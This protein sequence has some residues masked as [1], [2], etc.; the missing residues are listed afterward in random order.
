MAGKNWIILA[1][2]LGWILTLFF[3]I[4]KRGTHPEPGSAQPENFEQEPPEN[5]TAAEPLTSYEKYPYHSVRNLLIR[6]QQAEGLETAAIGFCLIGEDPEPLVQW[7]ADRGL[8]PASTLKTITSAT[9]LE[10]L[11]PDFSFKT[12]LLAPGKPDASGTIEGD[13]VFVG[14]GDPTLSSQDLKRWAVNLRNAGVKKIT[15]RIIGDARFF[16]ESIAVDAW[17]WGD[18]S[19][20]YGAGASGLN[21]DHNRF[22][23]RFKPAEQPG[24]RADFLGTDPKL[25]GVTYVNR[26]LTGSPDSGDGGSVYG[27]PYNNTITFRG[28]VPMG[29]EFVIQGA[30]P[31]PALHA[32]QSLTRFLR[33]EGISVGRPPTTRRLLTSLEQKMPSPTVALESH[34]SESLFKIITHLH[35]VSDN[36]EAEC[37]FRY[38]G[39]RFRSRPAD[40]IR[41]HWGQKDISFLGLRMEDG[42]G[43]A[44]ANLIRPRDLAQ[45]VYHTRK[46]VHG[47]LFYASL[48]AYFSGQVRWKGGAMSRVRCYTGFVKGQSGQEYTFALMINNHDGGQEVIRHWRT[49]LINDLLKL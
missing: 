5:A 43:L 1:L 9:A 20:Y 25:E 18:V 33:L 21:L 39:Q 24:D 12:R 40:L 32:A 13:L 41:E 46:G 6:M 3:H 49:A 36:V 45:V 2:A 11:G 27:G 37:L 15:G 8:I 38:L 48:N 42:S 47:D 34:Q 30:V 44:R 31:D 7:N 17:D 29:P 23:A 14:G 10:R 22:L 28:T 16:P 35:K 4:S 19:N 26:M